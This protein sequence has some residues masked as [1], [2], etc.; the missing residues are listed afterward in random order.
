MAAKNPRANALNRFG[1]LQDGTELHA[2][3]EDSDAVFEEVYEDLGFL[4]AAHEEIDPLADD[5][6]EPEPD[7]DEPDDDPAYWG[8]EYDDFY[9][10]GLDPPGPQ[11]YVSS[12]L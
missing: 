5:W 12:A 1:R 11:P 3:A 9:Y 6:P 10:L 4:A 8:R 7:Y 2:L